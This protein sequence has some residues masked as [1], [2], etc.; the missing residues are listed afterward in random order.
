MGCGKP[1]NHPWYSP[2]ASRRVL[3]FRLLEE[4]V[5]MLQGDDRVDLGVE[6]RDLIETGVHHLHAGDL[7]SLDRIRQRRCVEQDDVLALDLAARAAPRPGGWSR[8][9]V[10]RK[11]RSAAPTPRDEYVVWQRLSLQTPKS[12]RDRYD[13][14]PHKQGHHGTSSSFL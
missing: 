11:R 8:Q 9:G 13:D 1:C 2:R 6:A 3:L 12:N 10:Q 7:A 5:A 14:V 4:G